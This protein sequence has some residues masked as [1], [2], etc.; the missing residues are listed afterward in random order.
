MNLFTGILILFSSVSASA[1]NVIP[2][3]E[4]VKSSSTAIGITEARHLL[5]RT[6][7]GASQK[8]LQEY[9]S[10][11]R[12]QAVEK[13]L[14]TLRT[15]ATKP[16]PDWAQ[17]SFQEVRDLRREDTRAFGRIQRGWQREARSWWAEELLTTDSPLTER[18]V[19]MWH[20]H[21]TSEMRTVKSPHAMLRQN[22]LFR[23]KGVQNFS[24]LLHAVSTDSA[25][26]LYLDTQKSKKG[27]PNENFARELFE[28]F[29][30]GEGNYTERDVKEAARAFTGY[31]IQGSQ[32]QVRKVSRLHDQTMKT[33]LGRRGRLDGSDVVKTVL[34]KP[35]CGEWIARRFWLEFVSPTPDP[36]IL[37]EWGKVLRTSKW[38]LKA[39]LSHVLKSEAFWAEEYRGSLVKSPV[40]LVIGTL[41]RIEAPELPGLLI[42][43]HL[44][45]MGQILFDPPNVAGWAGGT[46]WIDST[47]LL[48]RRKFLQESVPN[49]LIYSTWQKSEGG[50]S[51]GGTTRG[52]SM[53]PGMDPEM[54]PGMDPKMNPEMKPPVEPQRLNRRQ[55]RRYRPMAAQSIEKMYQQFISGKS[56]NEKAWTLSWLPFQPVTEADQSGVGFGRMQELVLDPTYQL[57]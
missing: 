28:L 9:A 25:M 8:T 53:D 10:L 44:Q 15:T 38:D 20:G 39:F 18:L 36:K 2:V 33:V 6:T 35:A 19:L 52:P 42:N 57:K 50:R 45:A 1:P 49:A 41:R 48:E 26:M 29:S 22:Q 5:D 46:A 34:G 47:T 4:N 32:G 14:A 51:A 31:R 3:D 16:L 13:L 17:M 24:E 54:D 55:I 11:N 27:K 40:D 7:F 23:E 21:F 37:R 56:L 12:Q 43:R 30:L